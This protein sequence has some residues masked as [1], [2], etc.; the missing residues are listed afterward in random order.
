[1]VRAGRPFGGCC[2]SYAAIGTEATVFAG[3]T[4]VTMQNK[5]GV[6]I[7][8]YTTTEGASFSLGTAGVKIEPHAIHLWFDT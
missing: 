5:K 6:I 4:A 3:S 7:D 1:M 8:L 2:G